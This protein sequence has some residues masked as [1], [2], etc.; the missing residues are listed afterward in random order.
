MNVTFGKKF[1]SIKSKLVGVVADSEGGLARRTRSGRSKLASYS[2]YAF[3]LM[4]RF[5]D[6]SRRA[7]SR[8]LPEPSSIDPAERSHGDLS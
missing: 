3:L 4:E 8:C 2:Q 7:N 1:V 5:A 6:D